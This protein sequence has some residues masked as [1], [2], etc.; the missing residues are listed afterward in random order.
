M[1]TYPCPKCRMPHAGPWVICNICR[2]DKRD[3]LYPSAEEMQIEV[4]R[5][6]TADLKAC[7]DRLETREQYRER[8]IDQ[9]GDYGNPKAGE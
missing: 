7:N 3:W 5:D 4:I 9:A 6:I 8:L 2:H 1:E